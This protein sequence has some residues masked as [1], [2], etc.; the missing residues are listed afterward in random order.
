M[1]GFHYIFIALEVVLLFNLLIGV[2]E[3]GHF[4]AAKWRG[5][6]IDRFAIWFGKPIWK[7]KVGGVEYALGWIPA[8]GYVALPQMAT[9]EAIEGKSDTPVEQ[10]PAV[11]PLDKIIVAVA[12]PLFSFL[13]AV[14][15]AFI[16]WGVGK[17]TTEGDNTT[18]IGWVDPTGPAWAAGLRAGDTIV[19][20][21]GFPVKHFA[22]TTQDSV[23]WRVITSEGSKIAVKY[24]RDGK[25][26]MAYVSPYYQPTHW[27][28]RKSLRQLEI[29]SAFPSIVAGVISNS[30]AAS[31]GLTNGDEITAINHNIIYSPEAVAWEVEQMSNGPVRPITLSIRRGDARFD[32]TLLAVKPVQPTNSPPS[33][34]ILQ[35]FADTNIS[36]VHPT[37]YEQVQS[38]VDQIMGTLGAVFSPKTDVGVQQLGGAV[39]IARVYYNLFQSPDGWRQVLWFSVVLNVNLALLNMLPLPVLDGGHILL[40]LIE[41]IRRR[42]V[43][44]RLLNSIQS[45][46]AVL[47][48]G[49]MLYIAFF[50]TGDWVRSAH[51]DQ[52]QPVIFAPTWSPNSSPDSGHS[53]NIG[54]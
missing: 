26:N 6:K 40:S 1:M 35:W 30:P 11:S 34:G 32:R 51:S 4:L 13:L 16:V 22:A 3:L 37:P 33:L 17:P 45:G 21:D 39:M 27:Y 9:M 12:G 53:V 29:G 43:S 5:L 18:Q 31:A 54:K 28:E 41:V 23:I 50:D 24:S 38:S 47:L 7:T 36:L 14:L 42:P 25:E 46:F 2:H 52:E 49:F 48:I 15:F 10:L 19:A 20:I 8:G 44:A